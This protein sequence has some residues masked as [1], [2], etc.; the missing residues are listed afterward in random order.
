[1]VCSGSNT[2]LLVVGTRELHNSKLIRNDI[3][4]GI[5]VDGCKVT[6]SWIE[7]RQGI[8][9]N[10]TLTWKH[11]LYGNRAPKTHDRATAG[12]SPMQASREPISLSITNL[13]F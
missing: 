7:R 12:R 8:I 4:I 6:E 13:V 3:T 11:H 10:N 1:M 2:K 9:V 5:V